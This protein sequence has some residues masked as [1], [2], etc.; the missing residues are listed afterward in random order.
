MS[1]SKTMSSSEG[2]KQHRHV[3]MFIPDYPFTD[4]TWE[5]FYS[6]NLNQPE[7]NA[8]SLSLAWSSDRVCLFY[9]SREEVKP[10]VCDTHTPSHTHTHTHTHTGMRGKRKRHFHMI[11]LASLA[12]HWNVIYRNLIWFS[13]LTQDKR[14]KQIRPERFPART[15]R[16]VQFHTSAGPLLLSCGALNCRGTVG[17]DLLSKPWNL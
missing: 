17:I 14:H 9:F 8:T 11:S 4:W 1:R 3:R 5:Y 13:F 12:T 2:M 16:I 15:R 6:L 10:G 7:K